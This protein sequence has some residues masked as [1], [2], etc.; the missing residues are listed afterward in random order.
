MSRP[1]SAAGAAERCALS[2]SVKAWT[3]TGT[4]PVQPSLSAGPSTQARAARSSSPWST[5]SGASASASSSMASSRGKPSSSTA[6]CRQRGEALDALHA[7]A[8]VGR[9]RREDRAGEVA[10]RP[11][12]EV[13]GHRGGV[14]PVGGDGPREERGDAAHALEAR[15]EGRV[16]EALGPHRREGL[17][18]RGLVEG[19]RPRGVGVRAVAPEERRRAEERLH[20]RAGR[21]PWASGAPSST[22]RAPGRAS[23]ICGA[24]AEVPVASQPMARSRSRTPSGVAGPRR[25]GIA[26]LYQRAPMA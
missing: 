16:V 9:R 11:R 17:L 14:G 6:Q 20:L 24:K 12:E 13:V 1:C 26:A 18:G 10:A 22:A 15:G 2:A 19:G 7:A 4:S 25:T 3:G 8:A 23:A 5:S 21:R